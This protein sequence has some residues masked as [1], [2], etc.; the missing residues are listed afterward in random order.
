VACLCCDVLTT[1]PHTHTGCYEPKYYDTT[2]A[3][4]VDTLA[5]LAD[6][7]LELAT[8]KYNA[9]D[10]PGPTERKAGHYYLVYKKKDKE[11][12]IQRCYENIK[13]GMITIAFLVARH[14]TGRSRTARTALMTQLAAATATCS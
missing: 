9:E 4:Q 6:I 11:T 7:S 13:G 8:Q 12:H 5:G 1:P 2:E 10:D 3:Q 14:G